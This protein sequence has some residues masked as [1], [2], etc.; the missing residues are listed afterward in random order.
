MNQN[1]SKQK[2]LKVVEL[3]K[4]IY[5]TECPGE[6]WPLGCPIRREGM[7]NQVQELDLCTTRKIAEHL[8]GQGVVVR[9]WIQTSEKMPGEDQRVLAIVSGRYRNITLTDS[10]E[11]ASWS[12]EEGWILDTYPNWEDPQVRCW[13]PAP[14]CDDVQEEKPMSRGDL[15]RHMDDAEMALILLRAFDGGA[16]CMNKSECEDRLDNNIEIP[17]SECAL[18][19]LEWLQEIPEEGCNGKTE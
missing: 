15:I 19:L 1:M 9:R 16:Y 11:M 12:E 7:C 5:G 18:C 4:M 8:I 13:Q 3:Q 6:G 17:E 2:E 14:E 10:V